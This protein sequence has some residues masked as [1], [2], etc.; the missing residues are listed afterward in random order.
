MV[1]TASNSS[2]IVA[3]IPVDVGMWH[4]QQR[5]HVI[6]QCYSLATDVSSGSRILSLSTMPQYQGSKHKSVE[7]WEL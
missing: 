5:K 7:K 4:E 1:N 2:S 3:C 6:L